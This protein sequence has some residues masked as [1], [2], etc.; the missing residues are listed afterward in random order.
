MENS[1]LYMSTEI[2]NNFSE[3][4]ENINE[5]TDIINNLTPNNLLKLNNM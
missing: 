2:P 5:I 4:E 3:H 1:S